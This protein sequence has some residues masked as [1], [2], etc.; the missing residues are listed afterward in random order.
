MGKKIFF[1]RGIGLIAITLMVAFAF[2]VTPL[3]TM[4]ANTM[5]ENNQAIVDV[6]PT[7]YGVGATITDQEITVEI[8]KIDAATGAQTERHMARETMLNSALN[9]A[10]Y[11]M[12]KKDPGTKAETQIATYA[13]WLKMSA[14]TSNLSEQRNFP[15]K[16]C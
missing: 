2:L 15:L 3:A 11:T 1:K 14:M 10:N 13:K 9:P 6:R 16:T 7:T 12:P 5:G 8:R 4:A